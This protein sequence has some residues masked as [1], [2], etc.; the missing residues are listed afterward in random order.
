M[1]R[2][3]VYANGL[4]FHR[5]VPAATGF[6]LNAVV[7]ETLL[8]TAIG[9]LA[10]Y[11]GFLAVGRLPAPRLNF[12]PPRRVAIKTSLVAATALLALLVLIDK[13]GGLGSLMLQRGLAAEEQI[14]TE[15]S[16]RIFR[17][18]VGILTPACL[19]WF[20]LDRD[21]WRNPLWIGF[22]GFALAIGFIATGS[23]SGIAV[24]VLIAGAIW[25]LQNR[26]VPY[27]AIVLG[28][29]FTVVVLGVG[30]AFR[31]ASRG[32]GSLHD[33]DVDTRVFE[34][35]KRGVE[36]IV[37]YGTARDGT[38]GILA[39][40]PEEEGFLW[41]ESYLAIPFAPVPSAILPFP[42][43][44]AGGK[45]NAVRI[46]GIDSGAV[47]PGYIGEAYWN[48]GIVG[49]IIVM[50]IF[51]IGLKWICQLYVTNCGRGWVIAIYVT[52]L[53]SLQP[54]SPA[55]YE[56]LHSVIPMAVFVFVFCGPPKR[57]RRSRWLAVYPYTHSSKTRIALR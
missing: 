26:R 57:L 47:P 9:I 51:G 50:L 25:M 27:S 21:A 11:L 36:V 18:L 2:L 17:Y 41:G 38:Y 48:F 46:H 7:A 56:F 20:A 33:V 45:L 49:V 14:F 28:A 52:S 16:A 54:S 15:P 35:A 23:R 29:V 40:V 55:I 32:A 31:E 53:F 12:R 8:L 42:K 13:A 24:P 37:S 4:S 5:A 6:E 22:F 10:M 44:P 39:S 19:V 34:A 3:A 43:P 1:P 30:G